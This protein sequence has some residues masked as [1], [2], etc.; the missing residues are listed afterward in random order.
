MT[1]SSADPRL[2]TLLAALEHA[3][4][5]QVWDRCFFVSLFTGLPGLRPLLERFA[6]GALRLS[7]DR[8]SQLRAGAW[9]IRAWLAFA[10]GDVAAAAAHLAHADDD[11]RWIGRPRSLMTES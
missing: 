5:P 2:S 1:S 6:A 10:E 9:H 8:P 11:C 7:G 3:K 4:D